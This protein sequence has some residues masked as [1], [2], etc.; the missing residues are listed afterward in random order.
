[1]S[2][3]MGKDGRLVR[4]LALSWGPLRGLIERRSDGRVWSTE[5]VCER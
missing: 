2:L 4:R 3:D 1:M 5:D